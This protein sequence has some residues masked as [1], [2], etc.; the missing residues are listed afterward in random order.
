M[1]LLP[2]AYI[3]NS[4]TLLEELKVCLSQSEKESLRKSLKSMTGSERRDYLNRNLQEIS[5]YLEA[6]PNQRKKK[7]TWNLETEHGKKMVL[8]A[9]ILGSHGFSLMNLQDT[10]SM[11]QGQSYRSALCSVSLHA[12]DFPKI[13]FDDF[14]D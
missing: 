12:L 2:E 13:S 3:R 1:L 6:T 5:E 14:F 9:Y 7:K 10:V 8:F 11:N 4:K